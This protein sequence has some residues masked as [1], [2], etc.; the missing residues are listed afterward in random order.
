LA[1]LFDFLAG[2][3]LI[4]IMRRKVIPINYRP[5]PPTLTCKARVRLTPR[6]I[7]GFG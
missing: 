6:L 3:F 7:L 2:F 4:A 5:N 1:T